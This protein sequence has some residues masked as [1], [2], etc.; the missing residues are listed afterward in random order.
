[1][2]S[3]P[4][5]PISRFTAL[6][7][8]LDGEAL[9]IEPPPL[10][11]GLYRDQRSGLGSEQWQLHILERFIWQSLMFSTTISKSRRRRSSTKHGKRP[12]FSRLSRT[13][14]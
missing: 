14:L 10:P 12:V 13:T 9:V 8:A 4:E 7:R 2:A 11:A 1:M 5:D 6:D 3:H